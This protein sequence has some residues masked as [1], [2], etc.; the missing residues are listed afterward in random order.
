MNEIRLSND[1]NVI[2]AEIKTWKSFA[3]MSVWEIG[4]RIKHVK[5][6]DLTHGNYINWLNDIGIDRSEAYR[7]IKIADE[8]PND[9]TWQHLSTRAMYLITTLPEE[10]KQ[11]QINKVNEGNKPTVRELEEVK[12]KNREQAQTIEEQQKI[13]NEQANQKPKVI[14]KESPHVEDLRSDIEQMSGALKKSQKEN[15]NLKTEINKMKVNFEKERENFKQN[16]KVFE[17][18]EKYVELNEA[19]KET[20]NK[21]TEGQKKIK[22]Q[23]EVYDLVRKSNELIKEVAPL[24]Y[25]IHNDDIKENDYATKPIIEVAD[26]LEKIAERLRKSI[27]NQNIIEGEI[28]NG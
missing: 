8:L 15:E 9:D 25:L 13:I 18:S 24:S 28:I 10:Q 1:L 5:E 23:K 21:L 4:K 22:A 17:N 27:D 14:E 7:Y 16:D 3:G 11:E 6:N 2:T 26:N 19:F 12:R 20:Q